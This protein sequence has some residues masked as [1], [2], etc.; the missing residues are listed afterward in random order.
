MAE[1][2]IGKD[3]VRLYR[4]VDQFVDNFTPKSFEGN[5]LQGRWYGTDPAASR[6]YGQGLL[7]SNKPGYGVMYSM[8]VPSSSLPKT[9]KFRNKLISKGYDYLDNP[10]N[11]F[12]KNVF[13]ATKNL[14]KEGQPKINI[15]QTALLNLETLG[16]KGLGFLKQNAFRT[17]AMLGSLP[18][19]AGIMALSPTRMGNAELPQMPQGSPLQINQGGGDGRYGRGSDGQQSYNSGQ[20]F[21]IGA[22]TGGPVSNRTGRGRTG[23]GIG[24]LV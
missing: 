22:T 2:I 12:G 5:I 3:L 16:S 19:Q 11:P 9:E 4:G 21:G 15:P 17:L 23:Y 8:D 1:N 20:G 24:G 14:I 6:K 18:F 10:K 7:T 13:L